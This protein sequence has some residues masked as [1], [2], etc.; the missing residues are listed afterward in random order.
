MVIYFI[1]FHSVQEEK[2][3]TDTKNLETDL[4]RS[5][6]EYQ[7]NASHA[8]EEFKM[9]VKNNLNTMECDPGI[10]QNFSYI[11]WLNFLDELV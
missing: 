11:E 7:I 3:N 2:N 5:E 4:T 8:L 10:L 1:L 6:V 9:C